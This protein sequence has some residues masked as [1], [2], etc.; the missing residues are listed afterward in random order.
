MLSSFRR[1]SKSTMGTVIMVLFLL[2]IVASFALAD[3][4][5]VLTGNAFSGGADTMVK[6]GSERVSDRDITRAMERR[7]SQVRQEN[8]EADYSSIARD[9]DPLLSALVDARTLDAFAA[10]YGFTL[11]KRLVDGQIA[12]LPG[13]KG[14][15]GQFSEQAYAQFLAQERLTDEDVRMIIRNGLYQQL[16]IA[17]AAVNARAPVGMATPYAS[18]LLEAREGEVAFV[19][20]AAFKAG[21]DPTD[22]DLARF[23]ETNKQRYMVPEQRV[24]R[25]ARI[26][27]EQVANVEATDKEIAD[28]YNQN[29]AVYAPKETRIISQAVMPDRAAAQGIA[30]RAR[31][32]QGFA[33]AAAPAGLS[34]ADV[35]VG[36]QTR[37][38][39]TELAGQQ[40]TAAAFAAE[41]GSVVGPVQSDIGWHVVKIDEI[42][43]EGGKSLEAARSEIASKLVSQKRKAVLDDLV[44]KIED[45]LSDGASFS[46]AAAAAKLTPT[47][48]PPITADG[49]SRS[50]P[51][52]KLPPELA[53]ALKSGFEL[54]ENDE[55]VIETLP[56]DAGYVMVAPARILAAAPAPLANIRDR[57]AQDWIND[58][59]SQRA[60]QLADAI[61]AKAASAA[62]SDAAKGAK[63]PV[64]VEP[65]KAR[66]IQLAQFRGQVPPPLMVLFSLN[67]GKV[68]TV[69]GG[70]SEGFYVVKLNKIIPGNAL[71]APSLVTQ[72]GSQMQQSMSQ[73][74]GQQFLNAMRDAAGVKRNE[75]AIADAKARI[76]GAG[77]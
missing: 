6:I 44:S 20:T 37:E 71:S 34:A 12:T 48:T 69:A 52:Y 22:A 49:R 39:F 59:A 35:S 47:E 21:L 50:N 25:I 36:P 38:Q 60:K 28:Y 51:D 24:L 45:S 70:E 4:Q 8:P 13:A 15:N 7:L 42:K 58:Q 65:V 77:N 41:E 18:V 56:N 74:Y 66:R 53:P 67:E 2:A 5:N 72:T 27:P 26:G 29:R 68:R 62:V 16:L 75:K 23:Y 1:L 43:R 73:E 64:R 33:A 40:V 55:P 19:P 57:V 46:E 30:D 10:K 11:S 31:G 61:G 3:L 76:A 14:L 63:A 9:F 32:G 17:P 54:A